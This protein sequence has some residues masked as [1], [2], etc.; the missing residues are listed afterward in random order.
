ETMAKTT[1]SSYFALL[2]LGIL[3]INCLGNNQVQSNGLVMLAPR[4]RFFPFQYYFSP[5][6]SQ[7]NQRVRRANKLANMM[8][9]GKRGGMM[10]TR[11][12]QSTTNSVTPWNYANV[13]TIPLPKPSY[14]TGSVIH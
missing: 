9:L 4:F 6:K 11:N 5:A 14:I 13:G 3:V 7:E 12:Q 1:A 10:I 8:R 2:I